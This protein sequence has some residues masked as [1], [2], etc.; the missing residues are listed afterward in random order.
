[1]SAGLATLSLLREEGFYDRLERKSARLAAGI[2]RAA[3]D[4]GCPIRSARVGSMLCA[5][6]TDGDV[7]DWTTASRCD[8]AAFGKY[9]RAMLE[10]GIYLAP[11]QFETA[12]VSMAHTDEDIERTITAAREAFKFLVS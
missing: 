10:R 12:F 2:A 8:T 1:M 6:F 4:A 3:A 11:S 9:F 5:F 7:H